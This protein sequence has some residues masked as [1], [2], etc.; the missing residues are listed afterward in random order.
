[1]AK[2][3]KW[4]SEFGFLM[5]AAGSAV[6]LGNL[7]KFPY[8]AGSCGGAVFIIMYFILMAVLGIPL[9]ITEMSIGR[10][11]KSNSIDA[12]RKIH[13][14]WGFAGAFGVLGAFLILSYYMTIGGWV[15]KY[16]FGYIESGIDNP[17]QY[18]NEF[19]QSY[20]PVFWLIIFALICAVIVKMGIAGGI[21]RI[22][23]IFLP[24]LFIFII[25]TAVK[26]LTLD[27]A[28]KGVKF[29]LVPDF[30][31]INSVSDWVNIFVNAM[32]Q[33]FFSLS[34]GMGT[35]ITYG[36][37]LDKSANLIKNSVY[38]VL[39]D[40]IIA[41]TAGFAVLPA[42]FAYDIPPEAGAGLIF[43]ALP[44]VFSE[45]SNG[46]IFA[47][48]FFLLVFFA[49]VTSAISLFEVMTAY[50]CESKRLNRST[51]IFIIFAGICVTNI[52][53]SLSFGSLKDFKISGMTFFELFSNISDKILMPMGGIFICILAGYI[54]NYDEMKGEISA[55]SKSGSAVFPFL[56]FAI[57]YI[58]PVMIGII[59]LASWFMDLSD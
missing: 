16:T 31:E 37:Y 20:Q 1:M 6:G 56:R 12:C 14:R 28:Y 21:E 52:L 49:A 7:W 57:R 47:V 19:T 27:G 25:I 41:V 44:N 33:V 54:W 10:F 34:L 55:G 45:I 32:G 39:F 18:F 2:R 29:F 4:S 22:S 23:K 24:L 11:T 53:S 5:A 13:S 36:S 58:A 48:I 26:S 15:L 43:Q 17:N 3:E 40:S 9:L 51:A 42:V 38:I 46:R 50:L 35:L 59:L 30:S 8:L